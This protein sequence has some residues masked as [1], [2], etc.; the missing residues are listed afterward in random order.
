M[1]LIGGY[2]QYKYKNSF[3]KYSTVYIVAGLLPLH[4]E[5]ALIRQLDVMISMDSANMH[6]A[7]LSG[8]PAARLLAV[9]VRSASIP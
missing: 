5:L 8:I 4:L 1:V 3:Q 2:G 6:I 7:A 9:V